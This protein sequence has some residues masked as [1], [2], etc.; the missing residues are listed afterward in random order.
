MVDLRGGGRVVDVEPQDGSAQ[1][2]SGDP[3]FRARATGGE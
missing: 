3:R 1:A 2:L